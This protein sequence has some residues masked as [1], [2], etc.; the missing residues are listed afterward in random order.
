[1]NKMME[2]IQQSIRNPYN[3]HSL[4]P[5]GHKGYRVLNLKGT[6]FPITLTKVS[7]PSLHFNVLTLNCKYLGN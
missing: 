1:M 5:T 2:T 7:Q 6:V 4:L 3:V